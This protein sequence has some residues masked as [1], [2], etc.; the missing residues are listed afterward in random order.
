MC[1]CERA[2][3]IELRIPKMPIPRLPPHGEG[4]RFIG[5]A[6][7]LFLATFK[8]LALAKFPS[9][10]SAELTFDTVFCGCRS[11]GNLK[12]CPHINGIKYFVPTLEYVL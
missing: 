7:A 6:G 10:L 11:G 3:E 8:P 5:L 12:A 2:P 1:L 9:S 4:L